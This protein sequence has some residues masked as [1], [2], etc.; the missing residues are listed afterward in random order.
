MTTGKGE[1]SIIWEKAILSVS[2]PVWAVPSGP[3]V[4]GCDGEV[5]SVER[6]A[7]FFFMPIAGYL[8]LY[9]CIIFI[10]KG[11][12]FFMIAVKGKSL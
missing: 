6:G 8:K 2:F 12:S 10:G 7:V 9:K 5:L 1:N 4:E 11:L 3:L